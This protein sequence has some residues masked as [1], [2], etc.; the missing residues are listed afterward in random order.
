[1]SLSRRSI[2][3]ALCLLVLTIGGCSVLKLSY[4]KAPELV[5]W[6][7]DGYLDF[8]DGQV[9]EIQHEL[10][11]L[12]DWHYRHELPH[13]VRLLGKMKSMA[14]GDIE[15]QQVCEMVDEVRERGRALNIQAARIT[16]HI[17]PILTGEQLD[18]LQ[19][20]FDKRNTEWREDW[21]EGSVEDRIDHRLKQALK[22][23][24]NLYGSLSD[25]QVDRLRQH[26]VRSSFNARTS[27]GEMQRRQQEALQILR[28]IVR[29]ELSESEAETE[30]SQ[31]YSH[32]IDSPDKT[33]RQYL[34]QLTQDSCH[35]TAELHNHTSPQQRQKAV[36]RLQQYIDDLSN[37]KKPAAY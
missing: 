25:Q 10:A 5:Y 6:W 32:L 2:M 23:A 36:A 28:K 17:A 1:M 26:L 18:H 8:K 27:Y 24:E 14:P 31:L 35:I 4:N 20:K 29:Q 16:V 19:K 7:L 21:M 3:I 34:H 33:Y 11:K 9:P 12:H 13:Y 22:R 37:V 15:A 30:I